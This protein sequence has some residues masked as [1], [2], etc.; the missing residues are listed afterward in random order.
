MS[1]YSIIIVSALIG[2]F[3]AGK[4]LSSRFPRYIPLLSSAG[5]LIAYAEFYFKFRPDLEIALFPQ[6]DYIFFKGWGVAGVLFVFGAGSG[7]LIPRNRRALAYFTAFVIFWRAYCSANMLY[8]RIHPSAEA[9]CDK[10]GVCLQSSGFTCLPCVCATMLKSL[11]VQAGEWEMARL[12]VLNGE[13]GGGPLNA[14]RGLKMKLDPGKYRVKIACLDWEGLVKIPLPCYTSIDWGF[15]LSHA[16][17]VMAI[18]GN[19]VTLGDPLLGLRKMHRDDFLRE[20]K[21]DVVWVERVAEGI[22]DQ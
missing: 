9:G 16:V 13:A 21:K 4:S 17:A 7:R 1:F 8:P 14:V 3:F 10:D 2:S 18:N 20:W 15:M 19:E 22:N 12:C 6:L 11:G 5:L